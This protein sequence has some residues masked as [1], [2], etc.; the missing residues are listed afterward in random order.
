[1][2]SDAIF[3]KKFFVAVTLISSKGTGFVASK[4]AQLEPFPAVIGIDVVRIK[5]IGYKVLPS[6]CSH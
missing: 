1:M 6:E 2:Y 3:K 4:L 5:L